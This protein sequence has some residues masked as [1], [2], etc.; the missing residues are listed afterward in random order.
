MPKPTE[1]TD[2]ATSVSALVTPTDPDRW[3]LGWKT[4]PDNLPTDTG[5][6]PN[7][8]QQNY[9]NLAVHKWITFLSSLLPLE[10]GDTLPYQIGI[11]GTGSLVDGNV[12]P[13][14]NTIEND[15]GLAWKFDRGAPQV[16]WTGQK[17][18]TLAGARYLELQDIFLQGAGIQIT[19]NSGNEWDILCDPANAANDSFASLSGNASTIGGIIKMTLNPANLI[20]YKNGVLTA[21]FSTFTA[22]T[23]QA[24]FDTDNPIGIRIVVRGE[25][26]LATQVTPDGF[27]VASILNGSRPFRKRHIRPLNTT[28]GGVTPGSVANTLY[29]IIGLTGSS[30][31]GLTV[32]LNTQ[33]LLADEE[34]T[35]NQG[36]TTPVM[37]KQR[38]GGDRSFFAYGEYVAT[39]GSISM[40]IDEDLDPSPIGV[41][42]DISDLYED[43]KMIANYF[44]LEEL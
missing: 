39:V 44:I 43:G 12:D 41:V 5:E 40:Q 20:I 38:Q 36:S 6:R 28:G 7:L 21:D 37:A 27:Q 26:G 10:T 42:T 29:N 3:N 19:D 24:D 2:W 14:C 1:I 23:L 9:W 32:S 34:T 15:A 31:I 33:P 22:F 13:Y 16:S 4:L 35:V 17:P 18:E 30:R 8:Q 25:V 11:W